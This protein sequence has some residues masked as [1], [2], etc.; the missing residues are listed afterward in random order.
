MKI[1]IAHKLV[2]HFPCLCLEFGILMV[3]LKIHETDHELCSV[4]GQYSRQYTLQ[5]Y[6]LA[7]C[8]LGAAAHVITREVPPGE[9]R[10]AAG[11]WGHSPAWHRGRS[12]HCPV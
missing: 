9:P 11:A 8:G 7:T 1:K 3:L 2:S 10:G 12:C 4:N 5:H 6:L